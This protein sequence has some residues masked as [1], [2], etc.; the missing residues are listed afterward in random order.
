MEYGGKA[1]QQH[2]PSGSPGRESD[3]QGAGLAE[4]ED[5]IGKKVE[6]EADNRAARDQDTRAAIAD[7]PQGKDAAISTMATSR[8][9]IERS[10]CQ[11]SLCRSAENPASSSV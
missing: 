11:W 7:E 6:D 5:D 4:S 9:G 8:S 3:R 10:E 1:D 2:H